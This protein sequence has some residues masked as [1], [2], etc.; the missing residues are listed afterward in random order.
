M[1]TPYTGRPAW[2][3]GPDEALAVLRR[4]AEA[5]GVVLAPDTPPDEADAEELTD[6]LADVLLTEHPSSQEEY[7]KLRGLGR[8]EL[9][10]EQTAGGDR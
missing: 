3:I 10:A 5:R 4:A 9:A 6:E 8:A 2:F 1:N 7:L